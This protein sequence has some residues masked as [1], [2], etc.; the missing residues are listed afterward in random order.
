MWKRKAEREKKRSKESKKTRR[1]RNTKKISIQK[2]LEIEK[3]LWEK[4]VREDA[5]AKGLGL[6]NR[7][8]GG[9]CTK[10]GK[11]LLFVKREKRRGAS[12]CRESVK[13][14]IYLTL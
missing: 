14:E 12:V 7:V 9:I 3:G 2:V 13:K 5:S 11:G 6:C 1:Q 10:K 8:K 4:R